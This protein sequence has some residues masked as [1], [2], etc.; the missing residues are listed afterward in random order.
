MPRID[1]ITTDVLKD[2]FVTAL[3]D[4]VGFKKQWSV[5]G[6]AEDSGIDKKSV[7]NAM[8]GDRLPGL[9]TTLRMAIVLGADFLGRITRLA[10]FDVVKIDDSGVVSDHELNGQVANMI[11]QLG[12][13]LADGHVDHRER[14]NV[15]RAARHLLPILQEW[16]ADQEGV[17]DDKAALKASPVV[18]ILSGN[19]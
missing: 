5:E 19:A 2:V 1:A 15:L 4:N 16:V 8:Q 7:Y 18:N 3:R 12:A 6:F 13:A 9:V 14:A 11:G 10:G 17:K